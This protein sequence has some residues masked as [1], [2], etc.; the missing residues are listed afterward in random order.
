MSKS[1]NAVSGDARCRQC[2]RA[3]EKLYIKGARCY[4]KK[5]A[6]ERR[7]YAPGWQGNTG[8]PPKITD[9]GSQLREKQ[10]MRQVYRVLEGQ[11]R[12]Y[13]AEATRR[14][15]ITGENL[16]QLLE[17]RL[18]NA[19]FRLGFATSR[20]QARQFV[21]HGHFLVNG[22]TVDIPSIQ[23]RPGDVVT[24]AESARRNPLI[25]DALAS[26]A[27]RVPSWLSLDVNQFSGKVITAPRRDEVDTTVKEQ[28]IIEFYSR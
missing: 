5:C 24:L 23:L 17:L 15:G 13:V 19:V 28:I 2:R 25:Q 26:G 14:R 21:N 6:I 4:S 8:R 22:R 27:G 10:K 20:A 9:Y 12:A 3:G 1:K 18:D 16:L 7:N 11:F